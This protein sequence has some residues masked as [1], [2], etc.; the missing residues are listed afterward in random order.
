MAIGMASTPSPRG[1]LFP[2]TFT[3]TET[4]QSTLGASLLVCVRVPVGSGAA[5]LGPPPHPGPAVYSWGDTALHHAAEYGDR[6]IVRLLIASEADVDAQ[7]QFHGCT[8]SLRHAP[9]VGWPSLHRLPCRWTPLHSA[10]SSGASDAI[11]EL[12]LRGTD[13]AVHDDAG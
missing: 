1:V 13:G 6:R 10:A 3:E 11:A 9:R 4:P 12:L 5:P 7:D 8:F 2:S